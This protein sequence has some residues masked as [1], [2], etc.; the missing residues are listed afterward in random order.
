[1]ATY[2]PQPTDAALPAKALHVPTFEGTPRFYIIA[3]IPA[4]QPVH[5]R[6]RADT[7]APILMT[8]T[9]GSTIS[10]IA[11]T[12]DNAWFQVILPDQRLAWVASDIVNVEWSYVPNLPVARAP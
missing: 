8:L 9:P 3:I 1:M 7:T 5:A 12:A 6:Y 2:T 10:A 4:G 11:R